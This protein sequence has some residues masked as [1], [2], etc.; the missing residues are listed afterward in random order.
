M[1]S[2]SPYLFVYGTLREDAGHEMFRV[3]AQNASLLSDATV[4]GS[5]YSLGEYPALVADEEVR[6]T[7]HGEVYQLDDRSLDRTL[8]LL[9]DYEGL[10]PSDPEPHEYRRELVWATLPNGR[11]IRAW[12]YVFNRPVDGLARIES[13]DF[14]EWRRSRGA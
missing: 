9:D 6:S 8:A 3:L 1:K 14:A 7:V 2:A 5:L 11:R 13:G 10:A 12:A 4:R